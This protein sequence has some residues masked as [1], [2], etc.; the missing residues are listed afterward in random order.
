MCGFTSG[1]LVPNN[2]ECFCVS[3]LAKYQL[4]VQWLGVHA[5]L[6]E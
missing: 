3:V 2:G 6:L 5:H 4:N 1:I